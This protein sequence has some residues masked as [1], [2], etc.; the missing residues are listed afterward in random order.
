[1]ND[2]TCYTFGTNNVVYAYPQ[3]ECTD[4]D[5]LPCYTSTL[6]E[7]YIIR[8][9]QLYKTGSA[10]VS[11]FNCPTAN[12]YIYNANTFPFYDTT[13]FILPATLICLCFFAIIWRWFFRLRA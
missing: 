13:A 12:G 6:Q 5:T 7:I 1:M 3:L 9:G 10:T 11:S 4:N 2:G 8:D